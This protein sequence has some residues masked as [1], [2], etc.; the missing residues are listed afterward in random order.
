MLRS[1]DT[2]V[3]GPRDDSRGYDST[4]DI[5][6]SKFGELAFVAYLHDRQ[7][8]TNRGPVVV[9]LPALYV[10]LMTSLLILSLE[11]Q[12]MSFGLGRERRI[13]GKILS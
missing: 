7:D 9:S 1:V 3:P 8:G 12:E 11:G 5:R 6:H 13:V 10:R 4:I 2:L